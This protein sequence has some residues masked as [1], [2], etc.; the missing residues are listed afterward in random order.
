MLFCP[1][2][3][4]KKEPSDQ[5]SENRFNDFGNV[6]SFYTFD[7]PNKKTLELKTHLHGCGRVFLAITDSKDGCI[8]C[9]KLPSQEWTTKMLSWATNQSDEK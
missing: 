8:A 9:F 5:P 6:G 4:G 7:T 3:L 2:C 1:Y